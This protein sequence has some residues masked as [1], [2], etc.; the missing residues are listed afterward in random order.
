V[1]TPPERIVETQ[2]IYDGHL[3]RFRVDT[4]VLPN[5]RTAIREIVSTPGAVAIIPLTGDGQV[6]MVRQYRSAVGDFLLELPAGTLHPGE[7]PQD[8]APRE[9]AEE[10]GDRAD[11]WQYLSSFHTMPGVCD[12]VIHLFLA[13][14]LVPGDTNRDPDEIIEVITLPLARAL[15]MVASGQIRD[16]KTIVGLFMA[17]LPAD[18]SVTGR[19]G[20]PVSG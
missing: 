17:Q 16:A 15:E 3:V 8:A 6:R 19:H 11:H 13:T 10:T 5:S 12:E 18:E 1:S 4:V 2:P 20:A 14:D 7:A 9:L